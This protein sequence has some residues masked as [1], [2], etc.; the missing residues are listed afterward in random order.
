MAC[1]ENLQKW[2]LLVKVEGGNLGALT[3]FNPAEYAASFTLS[4]LYYFILNQSN[5]N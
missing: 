2:C 4:K 1:L 3:L 5:Q